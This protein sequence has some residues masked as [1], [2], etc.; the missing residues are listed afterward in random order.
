MN[1]LKLGV[2]DLSGYTTIN[3]LEASETRIKQLLR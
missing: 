3:K 2:N 1:F